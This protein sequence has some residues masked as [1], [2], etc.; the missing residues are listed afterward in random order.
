MHA[1]NRFWVVA[2]VVM[3][4]VAGVG[5]TLAFARGATQTAQSAQASGDGPG[6]DVDEQDAPAVAPPVSPEEQARQD[7]DQLVRAYYAAENAAFLDPA[8]DPSSALDPYLRNPASGAR[9]ADI[10]TFRREGH[11]LDSRSAEVHSVAI[12]ALALDEQPGTATLVECH[13]LA[14]AG[15][16]GQTGQ[17][18]SFSNRRQTTWTAVALPD[19]TWRLKTYE[20]A[21]VGSC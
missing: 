9:V 13:T 8:M 14:A 19:G 11:Q 7:L 20:S 18:A 12:A 6:K 2:L 21:E 5:L 15:L 3:L 4:A 10:L 16:D 1:V 17:P